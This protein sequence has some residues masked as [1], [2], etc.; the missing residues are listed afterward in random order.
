MLASSGSCLALPRRTSPYNTVEQDES[1]PCHNSLGHTSENSRRLW[2]FV[3]CVRGKLW[4]I[5]ENFPESRNALDS[6]TSGTRK[7]KSAANLGSTPPGPWTPPSLRVFLWIDIT[8]FSSFSEDY[9]REN[10][11]PKK[12][13]PSTF[14]RSCSP[15]LTRF[16]QGSM[17]SLQDNSALSQI[18]HV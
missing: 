17:V 3:K 2:L 12:Y 9:P 6:W 13:I 5:S 4:E 8:T 14:F 7:G 11:F 18:Y 15:V 16:I 10:Y 1:T